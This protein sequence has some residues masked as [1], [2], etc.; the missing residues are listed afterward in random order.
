M[1]VVD[2][3]TGP[4]VDFLVEG[5]Q[6][7]MLDFEISAADPAG[8]VVVGVAGDLIRQLSTALVGDRGE[9]VLD[10]EIQGAVDRGFGEPG[11][12]R[13]GELEN[14]DVFRRL[15]SVVAHMDSIVSG[16]SQ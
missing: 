13:L 8:E 11:Q 6:E 9:T 12:F 3:E 7:G 2:A 5:I 4:G 15:H 1:L 16:L 10:Q 14:L